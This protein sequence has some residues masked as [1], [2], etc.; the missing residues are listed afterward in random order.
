MVGSLFFFQDCLFRMR[1]LRAL[2]PLGSE[3]SSLG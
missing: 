2:R 1:G 3:M